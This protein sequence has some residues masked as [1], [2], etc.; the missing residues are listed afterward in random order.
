MEVHGKERM[1]RYLPIV[2]LLLC[3]S[4]FANA[5][6]KPAAPKTAAT[7]PAG[8]PSEETVNA[9]MRATFGY[10]PDVSWKI[11]SIRPSKAQGLA[12]V[13]VIVSNPQG[14]QQSVFYVTPDGQHALLGEVIPFGVHPYA[15]VGKELALRA[16]G[17]SRGPANAAV[18]IV[19]FSDLQCPHCKTAQPILEKLLADEPNARLV[20]QNFPLPAHDWALKG[21]AYADCIGRANPDAFWKFIASVYDAQADMLSTSADEKFTAMAD[22]SGV[23]GADIAVCAA[24]DET[25]GRVQGSVSLGQSLDV[26]ATPTLFINGRKISDVGQLPYEVLK[27]LVEFAAQG[28]M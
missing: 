6:Q 28:G 15:P 9:F 4:L 10:E 23:K 14:K 3:L 17:P 12:Q 1:H 7:G 25:I 8:L 16:K 18:T 19:E 27:K 26:N 11:D 2:Y 22:Q 24:K 20:F 5:Q 13:T 21:A